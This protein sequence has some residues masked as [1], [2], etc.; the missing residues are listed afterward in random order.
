MSPGGHGDLLSPSDLAVFQGMAD[1]E[2]AIC[3][4]NGTEIPR[5]FRGETL[6]DL[7]KMLENSYDSLVRVPT[8]Q[9]RKELP[10]SWVNDELVNGYLQA[11]TRFAPGVLALNSFWYT[12]LDEYSR[13]VTDVAKGVRMVKR[14]LH[15]AS[16]DI[17]HVRILLA[18]ANINKTHWVLFVIDLGQKTCSFVDSLCGQKAWDVMGEGKRVEDL[19]GSV[20]WHDLVR[21]N[22][23][24][25]LVSSPV[26]HQINMYDCGV[27]VCMNAVMVA[28]NKKIPPPSSLSR[29]YPDGFIDDVR[30]SMAVVLYFR[31]K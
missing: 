30:K 19:L 2:S 17:S 31:G 13:G 11:L 27:H 14:L 1:G 22:T 16:V 8:G 23:K 21:S 24:F 12:Q 3:G 20:M 18:P 29:G 26:K 9:I 7:K 28:L 25:S 10:L 15:S 6:G 4:V 5:T